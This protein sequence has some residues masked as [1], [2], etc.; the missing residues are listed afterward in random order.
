MRTIDQFKSHFGYTLW[1]HE[2]DNLAILLKVERLGTHE[3]YTQYT[4]SD[5]QRTK[6]LS[7]NY[8]YL[9]RDKKHVQPA[10]RSDTPMVEEKHARHEKETVEGESE[11]GE[12]EGEEEEIEKE[13]QWLGAEWESMVKI[14][15]QK[16]PNSNWDDEY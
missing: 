14:L 8:Q 7:K 11:E 15:R 10:R 12:E 13:L 2:K 9:K 6:D 4:Y 1:E 5:S 16:E 3:S